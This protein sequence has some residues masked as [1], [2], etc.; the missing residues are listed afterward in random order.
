MT[1][2]GVDEAGRG[3]LAGPVVA[4]A[5]AFPCL[6]KTAWME[7]INLYN[8]GIIRDSKQMTP[9]QRRKAAEAIIKYS[10]VCSI[11]FTDNHFIDKYNILQAT[12]AAMKG[13]LMNASC[14]LEQKELGDIDLVLVDGIFI[15]PNVNIKQEAIKNGDRLKLEIAAASIIAKVHRDRIM[16][17]YDK[18]YPQYHFKKHKG[19]GTKLHRAI[20]K[21]LGPCP[22]HRKT[23]RG[24]T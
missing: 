11:S 24:V 15:I 22:I 16:E 1:V 4:A 14:S 18:V 10:K 13:A 7:D 20:L 12:F 8:N 21:S 17:G 9:E 2:V 6:V 19:Y 5:V 3:A 23:F